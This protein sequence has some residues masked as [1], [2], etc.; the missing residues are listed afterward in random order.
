MCRRTPKDNWY[1]KKLYERLWKRNVG[2]CKDAS[3]GKPQAWPNTHSLTNCQMLRKQEEVTTCTDWFAFLFF[4]WNLLFSLLWLYFYFCVMMKVKKLARW[5]KRSKHYSKK[6]L[7]L[8][9]TMKFIDAKTTE[10][11]ARAAESKAVASAAT[12]SML[13][14]AI[15]SPA[16]EKMTKQQQSQQVSD[17]LFY[18][19]MGIPPS[20]TD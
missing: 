7:S 2:L 11:E 17:R 13:Q 6:L 8:L 1:S 15:A 3:E 5:K 12:A 4:L 20:T 18:Q 16:F 9:V 19:L 14:N 10:S